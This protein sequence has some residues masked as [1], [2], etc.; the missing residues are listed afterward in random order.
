MK[1]SFH[2]GHSLMHG[3]SMSMRKKAPRECLGSTAGQTLARLGW[4]R[5]KRAMTVLRRRSGEPQQPSES[6]HAMMDIANA[7]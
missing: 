3:A 4:G 2:G 7:S 1:R 5:I 6:T